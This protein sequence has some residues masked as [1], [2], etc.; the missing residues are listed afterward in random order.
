[1]TEIVTINTSVLLFDLDGTLV[2]ST[3][4]V[5]KTWENQ[6]NQHNQEFPDKFIDL[7]TL[8]NVS[9]GSRTVETFA[10]YFPELKTDR[11]S[12]YAWE[13]GIVQNYGHLGK[14]INGS[15]QT[16]ITLNEKN[17][18]WAIV[19]SANP[20]LAGFWLDKLFHGVK[21]PDVFITASDVSK[22]K[23]DPEGYCTAFERLKKVYNLNGSAKGVVFEDAPAGIK[24]G[25]NGGFTVVG[26]ASTFPKEVLLQAGATYVVEDFTKVKIDQSGEA[27]KLVLEI[28]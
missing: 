15:V 1:M 7:P 18:P 21:K 23:P 8:L 10:A 13:M 24:A 14:A 2:D 25:V 27:V 5:E 9:H 20:K 17:N 11:D 22:G 16:L 26:I 6:V 28:L 4:A 3:A 19:T 12:V